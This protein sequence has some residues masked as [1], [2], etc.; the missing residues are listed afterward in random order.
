VRG[1]FVRTDDPAPTMAETRVIFV[2]TD[3]CAPRGVRPEVLYPPS[4]FVRR[5]S[6]ARAYRLRVPELAELSG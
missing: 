6:A 5:V 3:D 2:R 4:A 1:I